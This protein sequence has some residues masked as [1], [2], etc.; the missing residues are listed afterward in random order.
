MDEPPDGRCGRERRRPLERMA[1]DR[2]GLV[3]EMESMLG[4]RAQ[5]VGKPE[6]LHRRLGAA[7]SARAGR[8]RRSAPAPPPSGAVGRRRQSAASDCPPTSAA[9]AARP[10]GRRSRSRAASRTPAAPG[11]A[12]NAP[13]SAGHPDAV[14]VEQRPAGGGEGRRDRALAGAGLP[15]E[16][17]RP[18]ARADGAGRMQHQIA[19]QR[20]D[21]GQHVIE[22]QVR[23]EVGV[24]RCRRRRAPRR[25]GSARTSPSRGTP[26]RV[27]C[28]SSA[29]PPTG[30]PD[31]RSG[32]G[33]TAGSV[34]AERDAVGDVG[35][36]RLDPGNGKLDLAREHEPVDQAVVVGRRHLSAHSSAD[37]RARRQAR[38]A[39]ARCAAIQNGRRQ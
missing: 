20:D 23:D 38:T 4:D 19:A 18:A 6:A 9:R 30:R 33:T 7:P 37:R 21:A 24:V 15:E 29:R 27:G 36:A 26:P 12:R 14:V 28:R 16:Q 31:R 3:G 8:R 1:G 2:R 17:V 34:G 25:C 11:T 35:R 10:A 13:S 5:R 22:Q 39:G 32:C